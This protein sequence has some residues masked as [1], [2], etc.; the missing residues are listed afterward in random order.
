MCKQ[1]YIV[2]GINN[3]KIELVSN[4]DVRKLNRLLDAKDR[5]WIAKIKQAREEIIKEFSYSLRCF[6]EDAFDEDDIVV[7]LDDVLIILNKLI[8]ESESK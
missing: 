2:N 3:D 5:M 8:A 4:Y 7:D 1:R 6:N